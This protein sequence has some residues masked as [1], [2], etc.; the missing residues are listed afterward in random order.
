MPRRPKRPVKRSSNIISLGSRKEQKEKSIRKRYLSTED[1][2]AELE[3]DLLRAIEAIMQMEERLD[4]QSRLI[5]GLV[6]AL[7]REYN[8]SEK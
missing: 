8:T 7:K 2:V 5:R 4:G 3:A 6:S 1:R